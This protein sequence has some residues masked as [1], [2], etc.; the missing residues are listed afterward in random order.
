[1][2]K[3]IILFWLLFCDFGLC[4]KKQLFGDGSVF[5]FFFKLFK[6]LE[7]EYSVLFIFDKYEFA[8]KNLFYDY[9][10][11]FEVDF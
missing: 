1:M 3:L 7:G 11:P 8:F 4:F 5:Y 6:L 9:V 2:F 10:P